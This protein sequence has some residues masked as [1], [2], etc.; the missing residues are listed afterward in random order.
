MPLCAIIKIL[1]VQILDYRCADAEK[2]DNKK[3]VD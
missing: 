2:L 1:D 3:Q